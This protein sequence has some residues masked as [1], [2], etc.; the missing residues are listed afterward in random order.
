MTHYLVLAHQTATSRE[1]L[2]RASELAADDPRATFTL[3]VPATPVNHLLYWDDRETNQVARER[4]E[5]A[6]TLFESRGL[7]VA[8]AAV[9]DGWPLLAIEDELRARPGTYDAIILSTLPPGIS[10]WLRLDPHNQA[11][12]R[13]HIPVIHVVS[14]A[15]VETAA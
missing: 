8:R 12:R 14:H 9:G 15:P 5:E 3:L 1:L 11:E 2:H 13:F 6:R 10:R 7:N 4:A